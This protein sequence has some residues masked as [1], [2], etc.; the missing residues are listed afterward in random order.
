MAVFLASRISLDLVCAAKSRPP[1]AR[2]GDL[3]PATAAK[4][5]QRNRAN[6]GGGGKTAVGDDGKHETQPSNDLL[7][8][9]IHETPASI[10]TPGR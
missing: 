5:Q 8:S 7:Q 1:G 4:S 9:G 3:I 10:T 6:R 2:A